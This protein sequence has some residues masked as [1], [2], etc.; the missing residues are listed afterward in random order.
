MS[1]PKR[2]P[3][4]ESLTTDPNELQITRI[5]TG[6][7]LRSLQTTFDIISSGEDYNKDQVKSMTN[8]SNAMV[9]V[10]R[11]EFDVYKFFSSRVSTTTRHEV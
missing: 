11:F 5:K 4:P 10:L 8:I 7:V 9:K 3:Q 2:K 6:D 1:E